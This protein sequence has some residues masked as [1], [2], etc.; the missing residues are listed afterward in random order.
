MVGAVVGLGLMEAGEHAVKSM[1]KTSVMKTGIFKLRS[2]DGIFIIAQI[3]RNAN[4]T[5]LETILFIFV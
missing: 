1:T 5:W 4:Q 2:L 3:I